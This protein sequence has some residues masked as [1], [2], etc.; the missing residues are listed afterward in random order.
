MAYFWTHTAEFALS[1]FGLLVLVSAGV[2]LRLHLKNRQLEKS[3]VELKRESQ[4][5]GNLI[6]ATD[7]GTWEWLPKTGVLV[8]N[9]RWLDILGFTREASEPVTIATWMDGIHPDDA[10]LSA[11]MMRRCLERKSEY[12]KCDLRMKHSNGDWIWVKI[13]GR[14]V[15]WSKDKAVRIA[16]TLSDITLRKFADQ[17][18]QHRSDVLQMLA[19]DSSLESVLDAIARDIHKFDRRMMCSISMSDPQGLLPFFTAAPNLPPEFVSA[20]DGFAKAQSRYIGVVASTTPII[21][22]D[23]S[24]NLSWAPFS[25]MAE[26]VGLRSCWAQPIISVKGQLLGTFCI[27]HRNP[28]SP[29]PMQLKW[30]EDEARLSA[31]AIEKS[32][33]VTRHQLAANVF[34]HAREGITIT[35]PMANIIEANETFTHITGYSREDVIGKNSRMFQS[36]QHT[37]DFYED[38]W[39]DLMEVG[40]WSGELWNKRKNGEL[41]AQMTTISAVRDAG[42][43]ITNFVALFTDITAI[44]NHQRQLEHIAHYDALTGLPNR[45]LLADR[46]QQG[47]SQ[48]QR[49]KRSMAVAY[50]DLDGFKAVNDTH[51]HKYGDELLIEVSRRMK[52]VMRDGDT[53]ARIGGDEFVAVMVDLEMYQDTDS[54]LERLLLAAS[55]PVYVN[56]KVLNVS[57]SIGVTV[58][59]DDLSDADMLMRHADQAM[60][61]AKQSG[62]NRVHFFDVKLD[63]AVQTHHVN[64]GQLRLALELNQLDLYFQPKVNLATS[65]VVGFEALI[66]W[67]HPTRGLLSPVDF[68]TDVQDK[69]VSVEIGEWVI[70]AALRQLSEWQKIG[71]HTSVSVNIGAM[72]LQQ[73]E[74]LERIKMLL[75]ANPD[76]SPTKLEFEILET[77]AL[78]DVDTVSEVMH[79]CRTIGIRFAL[80]DF[81]TGYSS[82]AYL[83]HLPAATLKIDQSFVRDMLSDADDLSIV[84]SIVGLADA[85]NRDV[86]AEG[87]ESRDHCDVLLGLGCEVAQ[88]FGI[89]S[90]MSSEE[91]PAW[92]I[93]WKANGL[94]RRSRPRT[95][96]RLMAV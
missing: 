61:S 63:A 91:I 74:F 48:S 32:T 67:N 24:T 58:Y 28:C 65:D 54:V 95:R 56:S 2:T 17:R 25:D 81:G 52:A 75:S 20:L 50:L 69:P 6:W 94:E 16:G 68:L 26:K 29:N 76:V 73:S 22:H 33:S 78:Q 41:Y 37:R 30:M 55:E 53:L 62:K 84:K 66:R 83:K 77:S 72:Q 87:V 19:S 7:S 47:I 4:R 39:L 45:V 51:G 36:G 8:V 18:E 64:L 11:D 10:K 14:V 3:Q 93:H 57:A 23:I 13:R 71:I 34:T 92:L 89:A 96:P 88:G 82:L 1:L 46:L 70:A 31:L 35:D 85:F 38:M 60:Y 43:V 21:A 9:D 79:A 49:Y 80:D 15:E 44:K 5:L 59:P 42:G 40:H 86:I 90:P 27:F 12:Y